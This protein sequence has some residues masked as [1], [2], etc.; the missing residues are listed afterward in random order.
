MNLK[1]SPTI[2]NKNSGFTLVESLVAISI[3][4]V[5]LITLMVALTNSI[6]DTTYAKNKIIAGYLAQEGLEDMRN[7]RD[8]YIIYDD[9]HTGWATFSGKML[10]CA[11]T[12]GCSLDTPGLFSGNDRHMTEMT[13]TPCPGSGCPFLHYNLDN[14]EYYTTQPVGGVAPARYTTSA[15]RREIL[16]KQISD[17]EIQVSSII[18]WNQGS[19][20]RSVTLT[21]ELFNW[22]E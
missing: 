17:D 19:G 18:S 3:F 5:A 13:L 2:E 15:F 10:A 9:D 7:M 1:Y 14:G 20:A 8:D 12:S 21:E 16:T 11:G 4:S 6:T 22:I